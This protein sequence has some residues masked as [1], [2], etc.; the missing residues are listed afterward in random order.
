[1]ATKIQMRRGTAAEWTAANPVL[2]QGE[3]GLETDTRRFKVGDGTTAWAGLAYDLVRGTALPEA[4][5]GTGAA[6]L[7]AATVTGR[8]LSSLADAARGTVSPRTYGAVCDGVTDDTAAVQA[9]LAALGTAAR[10]IVLDAPCVVAAN[11]V[12]PAIH[13]VRVEGNGA[14]VGSGVVA[15]RP[16]GSVGASAPTVRRLTGTRIVDYGWGTFTSRATATGPSVTQDLTKPAQ[17]VTWSSATVDQFVEVI[18]DGTW[19][20]SAT[21]ELIADLGH[22]RADVLTNCGV[23]LSSDVTYTSF[24]NY[25]SANNFLVGGN[26]LLPRTTTRVP[27]SAFTAFGAF[28]WANVKH[29]AIR[30]TRQ[31]LA[32][33]A[34]VALYVYGLWANVTARP[35]VLLTF[36]DGAASLYADAYPIMQAAG[37]RGTAYLIGSRIATPTA[38]SMTLAQARE[39]YAAGW[40]MANHTWSHQRLTPYISSYSRVG[41]TAT[42]VFSSP[43]GLS[44]GNSITV[45]GC[46]Q[47]EYNG[48]FTV[49]VTNSTT[50][51]FA[52]AGVEPD[53]TAR[54]YYYVAANAGMVR[55]EL[56]RNRDWLKAQGWTRSA[57]HLA[58]PYGGWDLANIAIAR[59]EVGIK[60]ARAVGPSNAAKYLIDTTAGIG[61]PH[62]LPGYELGPTTTAAAALALVDTA[63]SEQATLILFGHQLKASSPGVNEM[64]TSEFQ[65]LING[66]VTR[67]NAGSLDVVT[68][69][70]WYDRL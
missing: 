11:V 27:R 69:S 23:Y 13:P 43:H 63:I 16:W 48:T 42:M 68:I 38:G 19:D 25:A 59:D 36:D 21:Q 50:I 66:L 55:S 45:A 24:V 39:M 14:F 64:L 65:T 44:N 1:M 70:E 54:G 17:R 46:D 37:L 3:T 60:T 22:D 29:I 34:P 15:Y 51:T 26:H 40:D 5:G 12:I 18:C 2:A 7:G 58:Y 31:T 33:N 30:F 67:R 9:M 41:T 49:T 32:T 62:V 57:D 10:T 56:L 53:T 61:A 35:K 52:V 8:S 28:D 47:D 6:T 20:L 4:Q